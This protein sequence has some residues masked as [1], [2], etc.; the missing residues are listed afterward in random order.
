MPSRLS[1]TTGRPT[2]SEIV[3]A[4]GWDENELLRLVAAAEGHF[5]HPL[6]RA[7]RR[8]A[9]RRGLT[10][11]EPE[12]ARYQSGAGV[13]ATVEGRK[14]LIGDRR[15]L[16]DAGVQAPSLDGTSSSVVM[17]AVDGRYAGRIRLQDRVRG[18]AS[19]V[20]DALRGAGVR[21]MW[22]ATGDRPAAARRVARQLRL[23]GFT[24]RMMPEDK[25]EMVRRMRDE[26][27]KV[28]VVGDGINDAV[29]MAE[30]DVAIAVAQGADLAQQAAD[31]TLSGDL[32]EL[33][34]AVELSRN[35]MGLVRE[36][37]TLVAVPNAAALALATMGGLPP[38][39]ATGVNNGSTLVAGVNGLR[40]LRYRPSVRNVSS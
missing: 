15:L 3:T 33:L 18:D 10:L 11:P 23:D 12:I 26:G 40:P 1:L 17:I 27:R 5:P 22:L 35:A 21:H 25:A 19:R 20:I 13:L 29:A 7:V 39:A 6:A 4:G 34:T 37:V 16:E 9:R 31:V 14:V 38:L 30:A 8:A 28:A 2:V 24:A 36:N 32:V